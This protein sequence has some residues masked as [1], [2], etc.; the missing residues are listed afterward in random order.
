MNSSRK[1]YEI[2]ALESLRKSINGDSDEKRFVQM[3]NEMRTLLDYLNISPNIFD[4]TTAY[5][6]VRKYTLEFHRIIYSEIS[7]FV[8]DKAEQNEDFLNFQAN[9]NKLLNYSMKADP[10]FNLEV[11]K[12][13]VKFWDHVNLAIQQFHNL[14]ISDRIFQE[15]LTPHVEELKKIKENWQDS[16]NKIEEIKKDM[17]TQLISIVSIFV[18]IAFVMFGGISIINGLLDFSNMERVPMVELACLGSLIGIIMI[19]VIYAFIIFALR[20]SFRKWKGNSPFRKTYLLSILTLSMIFV[21]TFLL[22]FIDYTK[23]N[24]MVLTV[25][26]IFI[27][28]I[29]SIFLIHV[30]C[31]WKNSEKEESEEDII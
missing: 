13:I 23:A 4:V 19:S 31:T 6:K 8:Y 24:Q 26:P 16:N 7:V 3:Q 27:F 30:F 11:T 12:I 17:P 25:G 29:Y 1:I 21:V 22:W 2:K 10:D 5:L 9:I 20:L 14:K 18:A 28:I 15:K